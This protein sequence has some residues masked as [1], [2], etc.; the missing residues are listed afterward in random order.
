MRTFGFGPELG[1]RIDRYGSDFVISRLAHPAGVHVGCMHL[2]P[3][4]LIGYH[5][6]ATYQLFAVI[7]GEGWVRGEGPDR[8]PI[9]AGQ[10]AF[11]EPGE[12][13]EAGTDTG[14]TA[15]VVEGDVLGGDPEAI[16]PA[17]PPSASMP[18]SS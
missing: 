17:P 11:W 3:G 13:H 1:R 12:H 4:G 15:I 9:G 2:G 5:P 6:A 16:G 18:P 8:V 7:A 14:M 10:A